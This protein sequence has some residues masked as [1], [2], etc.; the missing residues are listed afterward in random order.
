MDAWSLFWRAA[1]RG[2]GGVGRKVFTQASSGSASDIA[3]GG[4]ER[5][6]RIRSCGVIKDS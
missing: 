5:T 6:R 2:R 4:V 3:G 1:R